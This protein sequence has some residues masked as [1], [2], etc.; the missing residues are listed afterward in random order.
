MNLGDRILGWLPWIFAT[1]IIAGIVHLVSILSMPQL[2]SEDAYARIS[3][4]AAPHQLTI[5]AGKP[6]AMKMLPFEDP[7]TAI[8]VCRFDLKNGPLRLRGK[9][10]GDGLTLLSFRNRFGT[11]FYSMNDRGTSRGSL[12]VIVLTQAQLEALEANDPDDELPSEL[13]LVSPTSEG[14]V[15]LRAFAPEK[16]FYPEAVKRLKEITCTLEDKPAAAA[17]A[18]GS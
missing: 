1:L 11:A 15:L 9:L 13:R 5:L 7:A 4:V 6:A 16:G 2:A 14:L 12:D 8:A 17:G 10:A 18:Q 3:R